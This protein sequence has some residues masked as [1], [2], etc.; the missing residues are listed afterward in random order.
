MRILKTSEHPFVRK[1]ALIYGLFCE[2]RFKSEFFICI[3]GV[4]GRFADTPVLL[5]WNTLKVFK[6]K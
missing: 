6:K 1:K 4:S 3:G 2:S 5:V